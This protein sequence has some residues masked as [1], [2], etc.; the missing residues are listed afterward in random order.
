MQLW[1]NC[2]NKQFILCAIENVLP[3]EVGIASD[4]LS[5]LWSSCSSASKSSSCKL[6]TLGFAGCWGAAIGLSIEQEK[7]KEIENGTSAWH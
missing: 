5:F 7:G 1:K 6:L 4:R 3:L 2:Q